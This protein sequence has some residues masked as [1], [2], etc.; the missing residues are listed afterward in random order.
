[1]HLCFLISGSKWSRWV[2]T[3]TEQP[4]INQLIVFWFRHFNILHYG[5][6]KI[7]SDVHQRHRRCTGSEPTVLPCT[8]HFRG[9]GQ[10]PS[11]RGDVS[12]PRRAWVRF[13]V[14]SALSTLNYWVVLPRWYCAWLV[15]CSN[16]K[17][18][19]CMCS[20]ALRLGKLS[21]LNSAR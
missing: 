14:S 1:M 3:E 9:E 20:C 15:S 5:A 17:P 12:E 19:R 7:M 18:W 8:L 4:P 13:F 21:Q 6:N 11:G 10:W 2:T 16:H